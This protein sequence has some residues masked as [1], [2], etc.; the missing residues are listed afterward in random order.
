M[1]TIDKIEDQRQRNNGD[2]GVASSQALAMI[3][4]CI[5]FQRLPDGR[6]PAR[7]AQNF[8]PTDKLEYIVAAGHQV[9]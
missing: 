9:S 6:S 2:Y 3:T 1:K 5:T 4:L 8:F 7:A